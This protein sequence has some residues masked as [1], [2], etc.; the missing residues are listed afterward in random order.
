[1]KF[2][3]RW[4]IAAS[5]LIAA[6]PAHAEWWE[7]TT[8]HFI[9][10]SQTNEADARAFAQKLD[11]FDGAL[12]TA[13]NLPVGIDV[14]PANKVKVF[15]SGDQDDIG[16]LAGADGVAGF[17][18]PRAGRPVAFVPARE[19]MQR[20][21][22]HFEAPDPNRLDSTRVLL[23]EYTHHFM[24]QT[25]PATYPGWYVEGFAELYATISLRDDGSFHIGDPPQHRYNELTYLNLMPMRRLLDSKHKIERGEEWI[26]RYSLGW[27]LA[28]YLNLNEKRA[29]QLSTYLKA[30]D[31]GEDSL[32]AAERVFGD[33]DK[34]DAELRRYKNGPFPGYDIKPGNYV[35]PKVTMRRLDPQEER[36]MR[37]R[38]RLA[39]G[40]GR[41]E[42]ADVLADLKAL[43]P[44]TETNAAA[45]LTLSE[46]YLGS[47][48]YAEA[49][50]A[51]ERVLAIDPASV[52]ALILKAQ[53]LMGSEDDANPDKAR[54]AQA[55]S[56]LVKARKIDPT[57]PETLILYYQSYLRAKEPVPDQATLALETA[58][59][60]ARF[61]SDYR[62]VLA[63]QL[64]SEG[65][66]NDART[67][68]MPVAINAHGGDAKKSPFVKAMNT[69][70]ERLD[71]GD[72]PGARAALDGFIAEQKKEKD[73]DKKKGS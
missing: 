6:A 21:T 63:S 40:V 70:M 19:A 4:L 38:I 24:L 57:N 69:V 32:A 27:L 67:V 66:G 31:K 30:I 12:R 60:N 48:L 42:A 39:R 65:R 45:Q 54:F 49:G 15:R 44:W 61:D 3:T 55:R 51:A 71:A 47:E 14:G 52:P 13:Q 53:A 35:P 18:I 2:R 68:L 10:Y 33:L 7:A 73:K 43:G 37:S 23:H 1:M 29:G 20:G 17:Y 16:R 58:F 8:D 72:T 11:R 64:L 9:V 34:L 36:L 25:F 56:Q 50:A 46:A 22:R 59:A 41:K 26:Q 5:A 62:I 28:H